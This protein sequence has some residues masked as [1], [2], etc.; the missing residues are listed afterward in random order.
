MHVKCEAAWCPPADATTAIIGP[1]ARKS[2]RLRPRVTPSGDH[3]KGVFPAGLLRNV[4]ARTPQGPRD[5]LISAAEPPHFGAFR[6]G[7]T[8]VSHRTISTFFVATML[9]AM[10]AAAQDSRAAELAAQQA[11]KATKLRPNTETGTEKA[12]EWFEGHVTD[13]SN[14]VREVRGTLPVGRIRRRPGVSTC[15]RPRAAE[16]RRSLFGARVQ[17]RGGV[18]QVS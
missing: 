2:R 3:A 18:D 6:R 11:D 15:C 17:G 14:L 4:W 1:W 13:P 10:P 7:T 8:M 5:L 9:I 12:L 16:Y